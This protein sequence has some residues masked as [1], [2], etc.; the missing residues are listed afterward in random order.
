MR[1]CIG[2]ALVSHANRWQDARKSAEICMNKVTRFIPMIMDYCDDDIS[3]KLGRWEDAE[4][5]LNWARSCL[6]EVGHEN[7]WTGLGTLLLDWLRVSI[8]ESGIDIGTD[9]GTEIV[10][11]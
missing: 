3:I 2:R 8:P 9:I 1:V 7:G 4:E 11:N 10:P 5:L 6:S